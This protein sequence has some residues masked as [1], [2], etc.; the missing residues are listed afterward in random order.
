MT[1]LPEADIYVIGGGIVGTSAAISMAEAE[2][3]TR[4][5]VVDRSFPPRGA[6]LRNA[7]FAC[8]G[9]LS[10]ICADVDAMGAEEAMSVVRLRVEGLAILRSRFSDDELGLEMHGGHEIF[11]D[12]DPALERLDEINALLEPI[13]NAPTFARADAD[14]VHHGFGPHVRHLITTPFEGTLH[15]GKLLAALWHRAAGMGVRF[16]THNIT[17]TDEVSRLQGQ[18]NARIIVATN[19]LAPF[20]ST[21]S[22]EPGRGQIAVTSP[23]PGLR[24]RGSYHFNRGFTYFRNVSDRV[25]VGGFRDAFM[26]QERTTSME[27]TDNVQATLDEFLRNVLGLDI[28]DS[29]SIDHRWAGIMGFSPDHRPSVTPGVAPDITQ[30]FACNGMGVAIASAVV[31]K[32]SENRT[33]MTR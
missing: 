8:F 32:A 27:T 12:D 11:L 13:F 21:T 15:S 14:I 7:G 3:T 10:E 23:I 24:L 25:L 22:L 1:G 5:C 31:A 18:H 2:P 4:I 30:I 29:V 20:L 19:A 16:C 6:T 33:R 26:D 17:S 28:G 9:S